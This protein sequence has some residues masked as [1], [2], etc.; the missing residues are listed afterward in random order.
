MSDPW[1]SWVGTGIVA[2]LADAALRSLALAGIA[3]LV[4]LCLRHKNPVLR[5]ALWRAVLYSALAMPLM[6]WLMPALPLPILAPSAPQKTEFVRVISEPRPMVRYSPPIVR[7]QTKALSPV[8]ALPAPKR[9]IPWRAVIAAIYLVGAGL[10]LARLLLGWILSARLRRRVVPIGESG[11]NC[12]VKD[13]SESLGIRRAPEVAES[14]GVSVPLTLGIVRPLI[15]LPES[16]REWEARKLRAVLAHE[17]AHVA[18]RDALTQLLAALHRSV[19]WFSPLGWWLE[20]HL[21]EL[22][23]EASDDVALGAISDRN[24]YAEILVD[25]L[26]TV[27]NARGRLSWQE[28]SMAKGSRVERRV[29]RILAEKSGVLRRLEKPIWVGT[30]LAA[31]PL[32]CLFAAVRPEPARNSSVV[33][34]QGAA[35]I[36]STPIAAGLGAVIAGT[37][38]DQP[39]PPAS[40]AP[41]VAPAPPAAP[42]PAVQPAP[43]KAPMPPKATHWAN[44]NDDE[45]GESYVIVSGDSMNM[46]GGPDDMRHARSLQKNISGDFIWFRRDGKG[47][48]IKDPATVRQAKEFF[49]PQEALGRQQAELGRKQEELGRKQ[50]ELG[51]QMEQVKVKI[52]DMTAEL[53]RIE[54]RLEQLRNGATMEQIGEAQSALGELQSRLG[55]L[56]GQ[57]GSEQSKLGQ[58]QG[59]LGR[60]QGLL[61]QTQGNLGEQQGRLARDAQA[62]MKALIDSA[63]KSGK[64]QPE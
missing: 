9:E 15:L 38:Q 27:R 56:Q 42:A 36:N 43:P 52:P 57:A 13:F 55:E 59:E 64:A 51:K 8:P 21:A 41:A 6:I 33:N 58:L 7:E 24:L 10:L 20:R 5:L 62:K 60:Q 37:V 2:H 61:G 3:A 63:L 44:Y 40:P 12:S 11:V 18:R 48:L 53:K 17:L 34:S 4:H 54:E 31:M 30:L 28:V 23:E 22:A 46:S 39:A 50:E 49:A 25:F 32:A 19:F 1:T 47:Y 16:W 45:D 26:G 14:N 29:N 35:T